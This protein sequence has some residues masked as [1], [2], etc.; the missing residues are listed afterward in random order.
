MTTAPAKRVTHRAAVGVVGGE[1]AHVLG[2][3]PFVGP[4]ATARGNPRRCARRRCRCRCARTR[5][6]SCAARLMASLRRTTPYSRSSR[7]ESSRSLSMIDRERGGADQA[8]APAMAIDR[9]IVG[10]PVAAA[11]RRRGQVAR[12]GAHRRALL[13]RYRG[14]ISDQPR[15]GRRRAAHADRVG[16]RGRPC[17]RGE[18]PEHRTAQEIGPRALLRRVLAGR[19]ARSRTRGNFRRR[20]HAVDAARHRRAL[21]RLLRTPRPRR[22][23]RALCR[24]RGAHIAED[25]RAPSRNR[26][27]ATRQGRRCAR[28]GKTRSIACRQC[29]TSRRR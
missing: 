22:L 15:R 12:D 7:A 16:R 11:R 17:G 28:G 25:P 3:L 23:A 18:Y 5:C 27:R 10:V 24:R 29:A 21:A 2:E 20:A 8:Y 26:R 4:G 14:R 6:G 19:T 1:C 13:G 9:R